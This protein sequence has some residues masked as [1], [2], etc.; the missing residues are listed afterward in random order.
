MSLSSYLQSHARAFQQIAGRNP[1][2]FECATGEA[3]WQAYRQIESSQYVS[4]SLSSCEDSR[5]AFVACSAA[6]GS[7][8]TLGSFAL[9]AHLSPAPC[10]L[11][12]R[13]VEECD[14]AFREL[15][16]LL[17]GKVAVY[18]SLHKANASPKLLAEKRAELGLTVARQFTEGDFKAAQVVITTHERWKREIES[19]VDL[20]VRLHN[21]SPRAL[22]V[23]D[24][25]PSL[26]KVYVRQPEDVSRL[27]SVLADV[28]LTGEARDFGFTTAHGAADTL[29]AIHARMRE[30]KDNASA[31]RLYPAALVTADDLAVLEGI[32]LRDLSARLGYLEAHLRLEQTDALW[33]TVEFL[34]AASQGR[35]FYS[36]DH[37]G[38]F[39]A[40]ALMVK[41]QSR[42]LL[43]DGTADLN[44]LY[45]IGSQVFVAKSA[46]PNYAPAK[47]HFVNPPRAF[48]GQM[49]PDK[50]LKARRNAEPY[51]R[52]FLRF[53]LDH[54]TDGE[55]V[56]VYA[57]ER[58]LSFELHK[59]PENDHATDPALRADPFYSEHFGRRI[60]WVN[61]GRGRG[62]NRWQHCTAYFRL[63]D[64]YLKKAVL[65]SRVGSAT[66]K[67][68]SKGELRSLSSGRSRDPLLKLASDS[69]LVTANK[70]DAARICIRHLAD[71]GTCAPARLYMVDCDK[72]LLSEYRERMFPG[73]APF[74]VLEGAPKA[75]GS[76]T[77]GTL[78]LVDLL[79]SHDSAVLTAQEIEGHSG[80]KHNSIDRVLSSPKVA[81]VVASMGWLKSTRKAVG[82]PGKGYVLVRE[83]LAA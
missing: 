80:I 52:W 13:T 24:E 20:G 75:T 66:G 51:V 29:A 71:D 56:L 67:V 36:K 62:S 4:N 59:A 35:V 60:H 73:S 27:A 6:T 54:T 81:P 44:G 10:A 34:K 58:L 63:G 77:S 69:H 18:T 70:Q 78:R 21:G 61:F 40:Y 83:P 55:E 16:L 26:E 68:Y 2:A 14:R 65:L 46:R 39:Y 76:R 17:P 47:L 8:K 33:S 53:L 3:L 64:F 37:G 43:L 42:T 9:I 32:T 30:V 11:V 48:V 38:A 31:V 57:K 82:L 15:E 12:I 25:D 49:K 72:A 50:L 45:A 41:P 5:P 22:V 23:V 7:G 1:S 79:L 74:V 19:G 28:T